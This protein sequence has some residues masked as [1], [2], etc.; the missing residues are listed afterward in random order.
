MSSISAAAAVNSSP[1]TG[2]SGA[3]IVKEDFTSVMF[4]RLSVGNKAFK[5]PVCRSGGKDLGE[6]T[7]KPK[8]DTNNI[9]ISVVCFPSQD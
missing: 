7:T 3:A 4:V 9:R 2:E 1:A 6:P 5:M 8:P